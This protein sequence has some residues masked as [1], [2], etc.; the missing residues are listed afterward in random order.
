MWPFRHQEKRRREAAAALF[1]GRAEDV[2]LQVQ[3]RWEA[4]CCDMKFMDD[5]SLAQR[6]Q[7]FSVPMLKGVRKTF[8][9]LIGSPDAAIFL[10]IMQGVGSAGTHPLKELD[11]AFHELGVDFKVTMAAWLEFSG[12]IGA[13]L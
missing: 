1:L 9:D 3:K 13:A 8:P 6:I 4:F 7:F 5:V 12:N 2:V 11:E 10:L